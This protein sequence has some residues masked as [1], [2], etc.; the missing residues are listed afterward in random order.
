MKLKRKN[1]ISSTQE[2]DLLLHNRIIYQEIAA[3]TRSQR[4]QILYFQII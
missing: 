3:L 4:L 2:E 1:K